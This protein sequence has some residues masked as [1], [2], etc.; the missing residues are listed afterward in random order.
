MPT[1]TLME[2]TRLVGCSKTPERGLRSALFSGLLGECVRPQSCQTL[3]NPRDH[4][5]PGSSVLG[6]TQARILE[7][8][9]NPFFRGI[10]PTQGSNS[11]L[12]HCRWILYHMNH[13]YTYNP[14]LLNLSLNPTHPSRLSE[15]E[16]S[17]QQLPTSYLHII[18]YICLCDSLFVPHSPSSHCVHKSI[19]SVCSVS[20]LYFYTIPNLN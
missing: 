4:S 7:W 3:C 6:I 15:H 14:S 9:A 18:A 2:C 11:G 13:Q 12:P 10:F 8:V 16:L 5:P 20:L 17:S 1:S 19:L